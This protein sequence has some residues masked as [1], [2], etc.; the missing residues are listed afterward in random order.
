MQNWVDMFIFSAFGRKYPLWA[1]LI[2]KIKIISLSWN[3]VSTLTRICRIQWRVHFF[4]IF[5]QK[6][7][8]WGKFVTKSQNYQLKLRF[9]SLS[10][11]NMQHSMMLFTFF[12]LD[13]KYPFWANL[14][15]KTK[16]ISLSWS[17]VPSLIRICR[18]Q[19]WCLRFLFSNRYTLF[20]E[21]WSKNSKL[22]L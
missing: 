2:Q 7:L 8:F 19:W 21:I 3:L 17:L 5:D 13:W 1:N 14:V 10:N 18:I 16:V 22:S 20:G 12:V 15:Q 6:Y 11:L 9:G 4:H